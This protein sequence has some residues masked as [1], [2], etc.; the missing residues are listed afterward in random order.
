MT[1]A[2]HDRTATRYTFARAQGV[3]VQDAQ[4]A[5]VLLVGGGGYP[6]LDD[7][8]C[9]RPLSR[10]VLMRILPLLHA[11]GYVTALVDAPTDSSD[12]D[13]LAGFRIAQ[14]HADDFGKVIGDVRSRTSGSVWLVGHSRGTISAANADARLSGPAAPEG[15][16]LLSA[17]MSGDARARKAF[18][19]Q[20]VFD[21]P[22]GVMKTP[23]LAVGHAADSCIRSPAELMEKITAR[24]QGARESCYG[25]RWPHQSG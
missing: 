24:T 23:V 18:V 16:V 4:I 11:A 12:G 21:L 20:T 8:G 2:T 14:Q 7:K 15:V 1:I 22:L 9:P 10:N 6:N 3:R 13:G 19:A 5:L 17:V 25:Y